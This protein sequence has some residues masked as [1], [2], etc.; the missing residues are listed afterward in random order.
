MLKSEDGNQL[1]TLYPCTGSNLKKPLQHGRFTSPNEIGKD[2]DY[3][4]FTRACES[5]TILEESKVVSSP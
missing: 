3:A 1:P 4:I 5:F 2:F